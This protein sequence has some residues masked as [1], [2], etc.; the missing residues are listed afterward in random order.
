MALSKV[1]YTQVTTL[2]TKWFKQTFSLKTLNPQLT[3]TQINSM[4]D[5]IIANAAAITAQLTSTATFTN[6]TLTTPI[7]ASVYQDA[8]K[9]KLMTVPDTASDT[10]C[11]IAATQTLTNK[12]LT[13]PTINTPVITNPATTVTLGTHDYAG[14][15]VDWTLSAAELLLPVHKPTNANGAVN[16]I[17]ATTIRPYLFINATG[18][19]LTVKTAAGTGIVVANNKSAF[20]MSDGTNVIRLTTDA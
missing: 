2:M 12:T 3:H 1:T 10:L 18:Q 14:A 7:V 13:S 20:V 16:A 9:T 4:Q 5:E 15:A 11:A 17:V 8:A 19:A 6:K